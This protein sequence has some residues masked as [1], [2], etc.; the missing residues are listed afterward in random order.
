[1][2]DHLRTK[3][4]WHW[5]IESG[6]RIDQNSFYFRKHKMILKKYY[7]HPK[8]D[9]ELY[10]LNKQWCGR[11]LLTIIGIIVMKLINFYVLKE[12]EKY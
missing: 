5:I 9:S 2:L 1:M 11:M 10:I 8:K 4:S 6:Q 12:S 3:E 7:Y